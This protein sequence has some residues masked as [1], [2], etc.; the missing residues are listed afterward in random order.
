MNLGMLKEG[1]V[2]PVQAFEE[3]WLEFMLLSSVS[4]SPPERQADCTSSRTQK[5]E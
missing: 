5:V 3:L 2:R 1:R 4:T